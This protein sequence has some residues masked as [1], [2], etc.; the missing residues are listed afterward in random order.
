[1]KLYI[2]CFPAPHRRQG[3]PTHSRVRDQDEPHVQA[4]TN[5]LSDNPSRNHITASCSKR[6]R[7]LDKTNRNLSRD[8]RWTA[9]SATNTATRADSPP[10]PSSSNSKKSLSE[11]RQI[12][13]PNNPEQAPRR[14]VCSKKK[15]IGKLSSLV[16]CS[17][18]PNRLVYSQ[19]ELKKKELA[20]DRPSNGDILAMMFHRPSS[21]SS[22]RLDQTNEHPSPISGN[23]VS[24]IDKSTTNRD[25]KQS[26][27]DKPSTS[28]GVTHTERRKGR[29]RK[30][31]SVD[32]DAKENHN[33]DQNEFREP[34]SKRMRKSGGFHQTN[35]PST[36]K[37]EIDIHGGESFGIT[38]RPLASRRHDPRNDR[39]YGFRFSVRERIA[40]ASRRRKQRNLERD[41]DQTKD[42]RRYVQIRMAVKRKREQMKE[43]GE[44]S[45]EENPAKRRKL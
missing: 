19:G 21:S 8:P 33:D 7:R 6:R 1:M 4:I 11:Q 5:L 30:R 34:P 25:D 45:D 20:A 38:D 10:T 32:D 28:L 3:Q 39:K 36:S 43:E 29:K 9:P 40:Q 17:Y 26:M 31:D 15:H 2:S 14:H 35:Q 41:L 13:W 44:N 27:I 37:A 42:L 23:L 12:F 18:P 16:Y 24:T 22:T